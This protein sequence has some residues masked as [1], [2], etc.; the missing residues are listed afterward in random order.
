MGP[1][2]SKELL[3]RGKM[4]TDVVGPAVDFNLI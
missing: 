4:W 1:T 2:D 3:E